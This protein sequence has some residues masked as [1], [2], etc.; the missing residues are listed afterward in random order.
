VDRALDVQETRAA[1]PPEVQAEIAA[2]KVS[3]KKW[4][5]YL[6]QY[7]WKIDFSQPLILTKFTLATVS[8]EINSA[9][10]TPDWI[11][12]GRETLLTPSSKAIPMRLQ[13]YVTG[14]YGRKRLFKISPF[15]EAE[16]MAAFQTLHA[17]YPQQPL[18][19]HVETDERLTEGKLSL[20]AGGQIIPLTHSKVQVFSTE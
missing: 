1:M 16:T 5:A 12:H 4:D 7:P 11:A 17:K 19:L 15:D 3:S 8:S 6:K 10:L 20:R 18:T 9:P 14:A 2:G 13:L